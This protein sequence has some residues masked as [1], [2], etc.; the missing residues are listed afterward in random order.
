MPPDSA[1]GLRADD[2]TVRV[3]DR[4]GIIP[5]DLNVPRGHSLAITGTSGTGKT[6]L[7]KTIAG[8][9]HPTS[10][11]VTL[12]GT[13]LLARHGTPD[14]R[15]GYLTQQHTLP[16]AL[17]AVE[18]VALPLL[19]HRTPAAQAWARAE[20]LLAA[21]G[22]PTATWHNLVEQL[23]GGQQQRVAIA[24]ALAA[25]PALLALD[26]PT[27][28]LDTASSDR[29]W[30]NLRTVLATGAVLVVATP[31]NGEAAHCHTRLSLPGR[32]HDNEGGR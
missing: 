19:V 14:P 13:P 24:R 4:A 16:G 3:G 29:V 21:L 18:N 27:S 23:S 1:V 2:L 8:L 10:G 12:N 17:T 5:V 7:L 26:D 9:R 30:H 25:E 28:E 32:R 22:L 6:T 31:D 11:H 20:D 15:V